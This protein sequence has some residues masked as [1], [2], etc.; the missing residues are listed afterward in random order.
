MGF[1]IFLLALE[2][3]VRYPNEDL[4]RVLL[5]GLDFRLRLGSGL[6]Y[7]EVLAAN[8]RSTFAPHFQLLLHFGYER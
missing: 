4:V 1:P 7:S 5:E 6:G 8:V 3:V 2:V